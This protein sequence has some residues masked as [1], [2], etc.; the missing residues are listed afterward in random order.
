MVILREEHGILQEV[1]NSEG[2][3]T[4][5]KRLEWKKWLKGEKDQGREVGQ[6]WEVVEEENEWEHSITAQIYDTLYAN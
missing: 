3:R 5:H 1:G 6:T 4:H 2:K